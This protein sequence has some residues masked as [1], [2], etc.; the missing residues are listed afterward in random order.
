MI[1]KAYMHKG[2]GIVKVAQYKSL[3]KAE[4]KEHWYQMAG[5]SVQEMKMKDKDTMPMRKRYCMRK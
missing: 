4:A 2:K 3:V 1:M 5:T